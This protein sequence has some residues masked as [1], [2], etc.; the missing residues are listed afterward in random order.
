[1]I[2]DPLTGDHERIDGILSEFIDSLRSGTMDYSKLNKLRSSLYA[3]IYFEETTLFRIVEDQGNRARIMGLETEHAGIWQLID[4]I[5]YYMKQGDHVRAV[6]RA[7][8]LERV[9]LTHNNAE[10]EHVYSLLDRM[11]GIDENAIMKKLENSR[12]PEGWKCR[13]LQKYGRK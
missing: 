7:E 13:V 5:E 2:S 10:R 3:H 12:M 4:K 1:M 6:D 8:G 9:L 11:E